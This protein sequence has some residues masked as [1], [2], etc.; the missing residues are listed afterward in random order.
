[1]TWNDF[2]IPFNVKIIRKTDL[3][4]YLKNDGS[5]TFQL[6]PMTNPNYVVQEVS[7]TWFLKL[8]YNMKPIGCKQ[9][10]DI[11]IL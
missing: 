8:V 9:T 3:I 6:F 5:V 4:I 7:A 11:G 1:M 2:R 10:T